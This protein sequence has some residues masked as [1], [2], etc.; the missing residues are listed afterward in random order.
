[1]KPVNGML[2]IEQVKK[3][4]ITAGLIV[5]PNPEETTSRVGK[6]INLPLHRKG[7]APSVIPLGAMICF[8]VTAAREVIYNGKRHWFVHENQVIAFE[9]PQAQLPN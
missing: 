4:D 5:L 7:E 2:E 9:I 1:M 8:H 6:V 3:E